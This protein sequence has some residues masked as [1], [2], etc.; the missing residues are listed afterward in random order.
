VRSDGTSAVV[1]CGAEGDV[2]EISRGD[3]NGTWAHWDLTSIINASGVA[4]GSPNYA[5]SCA[6]GDPFAYVRADGLNAI[7]YRGADSHI[8]E[9]ALSHGA[10]WA[11]SDLSALAG[12]APAAG[13]PRAYSRSDGVSSVVY[14]GTDQ[15]I[16]EI[17]LN[18]WD[19]GWLTADLTSLAGAPSAADEP[20]PNVHADG[21]SAVVYRGSDLHIHELYL[22]GH[23]LTADL[24]SLAGA[25][26]AVTTPAAYVRPDGTT[27]V[28]FRA[29]DGHIHELTLARGGAGWQA[30]DLS[31]IAVPL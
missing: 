6:G 10:A 22:A 25:P 12:A 1:Y 5:P 29:D 3:L 4:A 30:W 11:A 13:S 7:V 14:R 26:R 9:L 17:Y 28:V 23:W 20:R 16:H 8:H 15:H 18:A 31:A 19:A 21:G 24:T 2:H 27:A